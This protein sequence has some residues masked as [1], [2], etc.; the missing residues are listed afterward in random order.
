MGVALW[1]AQPTSFPEYLAWFTESTTFP[2]F[3]QARTIAARLAGSTANLSLTMS[4][5]AVDRQ[6][7]QAIGYYRTLNL[8]N[9]PQLLLP[10]N[11]LQGQVKSSEEL[12]TILDKYLAQGEVASR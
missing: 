1:Q 3:T 9:L 8:S 2:S 6:L 11:I 4:S 12:L 5:P 7:Q 10:H